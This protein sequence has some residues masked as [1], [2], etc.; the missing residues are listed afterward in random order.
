MRPR[1]RYRPV[2]TWAIFTSGGVALIGGLIWASGLHDETGAALID[3]DTA[4]V[5]VTL[6]TVLGTLIGLLLKRTGAVEHELKPNSGTSGRDVM[7]RTEQKLDALTKT[8]EHL[9]RAH[10]KGD[11]D[12]LQLRE[13]QQQTRTDLAGQAS[14]IRG[15][16][17]DI[18]RIADI[19]TTK[20]SPK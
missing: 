1:R 10:R 14:D 2:P 13:D 6:I 17:K 7:D 11:T 19:L 9:E 18:G 8:V 3:K 20:E 4:G 16:R 15:I 12:I 5:L